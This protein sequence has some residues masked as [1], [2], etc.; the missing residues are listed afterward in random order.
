[1]VHRGS[2]SITLLIQLL[3]LF[4]IFQESCEVLSLFIS[5]GQFHELVENDIASVRS[6]VDGGHGEVLR[7]LPGR[8]QICH[9]FK[10][11]LLMI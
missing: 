7:D 10:I 1:M 11:F 6:N 5:V 8:A 4:E 2:Y 9:F 3:P